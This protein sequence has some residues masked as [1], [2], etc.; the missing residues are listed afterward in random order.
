[1][2]PAYL[3]WLG[4][5][6]RIAMSDLHISL[7]H[8]QID[9]NSKTKFANRNKIRTQQGWCWLTVPIKTKGRQGDLAI[10]QLEIAADTDWAAKHW[11]T[12]KQNYA[13]APF[14]VQH[15]P[16][17]EAIYAR[18]WDRLVDLT[19]AIT[20]YLLLALGIRTPALKSS[21]MGVAGVKDELI[22]NLC[23]AVNASTYLSGPFGRD[24]LDARTF[25]SAGIRLLFHDYQHPLYQQAYP[26]FEPY[27]SA[28]D[29]LFNLGP[30]SLRV[31]MEGQ[32]KVPE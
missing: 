31:I 25:E 9:R 32:E 4:Y 14:F 11:Q 17:F 27:M 13:R 10:D 5:F 16:F 24:Y 8:V 7:D 3:P 18:H 29:L 15:A 23:K 19:G 12:L 28:V 20:D 26:G 2:Q 22:L 1:M 6:H 30:E 21:E